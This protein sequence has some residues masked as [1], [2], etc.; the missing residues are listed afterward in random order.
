MYANI[1]TMLINMCAWLAR[2]EISSCLGGRQ[3][4]NRG[5]CYLPSLIVAISPPLIQR[6]SGWLFNI[7]LGWTRATAIVVVCG[8]L[9]YF[10]RVQ[11]FLPSISGELS[12]TSSPPHPAQVE[13][14]V[15]NLT[16]RRR[17]EKR[18]SFYNNN[19]DQW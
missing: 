5:T 17:E 15:K 19:E 12:T 4:G 11:L 3:T 6:S 18:T 16:T 2:Q 8:G 9:I 14:E 1:S 7:R 13:E 10:P